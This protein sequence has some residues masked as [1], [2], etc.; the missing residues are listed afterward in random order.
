MFLI[1]AIFSGIISFVVHMTTKA[2][3][4]T[5]GDV[6]VVQNQT[7]A[8][9]QKPPIVEEEKESGVKFN[10]GSGRSIRFT[11]NKTD[12][13]SR[14]IETVSESMIQIFWLPM[15]I[16]VTAFTAII[17]ALLFLKTRQA[18]GEP[19]HELLA[20]FEDNEKPRKRW[21]ERVRN[22]LIQSGRVT[23]KP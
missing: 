3:S 5:A 8:A 12:M 11:E 13:R 10:I 9:G 20:K 4:N 21:Q 2:V 16:F 6:Q 18:G 23:S 17:V 22:R 15:H 14:L 1:P 7:D 19:M